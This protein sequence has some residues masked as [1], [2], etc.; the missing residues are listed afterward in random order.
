MG[1]IGGGAGGGKKGK[2][3]EGGEGAELGTILICEP[4]SF[5]G[6]LAAAQLQR[7][8]KRSGKSMKRKYAS[9]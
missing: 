2:E 6:R 1:L 9:E 4:F 3:G 5:G 8:K 7:Y